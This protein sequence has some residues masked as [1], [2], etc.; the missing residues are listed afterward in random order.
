MWG[1]DR[2]GLADLLRDAANIQALNRLR[3][4]KQHEG[5]SAQNFAEH[6]LTYADE[7]FLWQNLNSFG[8]RPNGVMHLLM[9]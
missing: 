4:C 5:D 8:Y 2:V 3:H 6:I 7:V 9:A 1:R